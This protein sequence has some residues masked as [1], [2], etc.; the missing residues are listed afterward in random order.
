MWLAQTLH[1]KEKSQG[2]VSEK[3]M[4]GDSTMEIIRTAWLRIHPV[5][6][7]KAS[8]VLT[9]AVMAVLESEKQHGRPSV[10]IEIADLRGQFNSFD[11]MGP[12]SS[13]AIWGALAPT[14]QHNFD[15][16]KHVSFSFYPRIK[17]TNQVVL[18]L[19]A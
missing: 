16:K 17:S 12:K 18:E 8:Q 11:L 14:K 5:A 6:S 2:Q 9:N 19:S 3:D 1:A 10:S 15:T 7:E 13:Q 4:K